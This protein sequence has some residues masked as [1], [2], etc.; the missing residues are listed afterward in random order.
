[1]DQIMAKLK[2]IF[3]IVF[4]DDGLEISEGTCADD[5]EE[6]DSLQH[7]NL[8]AMIEKEFGIRFEIDD[9]ITMENVGDIVRCIDTRLKGYG[10]GML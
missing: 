7:L 3:K 6:W 4:D 5:I 2:G 9:I 1:M 10:C 8:L